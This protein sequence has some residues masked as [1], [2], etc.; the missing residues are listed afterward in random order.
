MV[1][2]PQHLAFINRFF[3][4]IDTAQARNLSLATFNYLAV[5]EEE[6][7]CIWKANLFLNSAPSK[8]PFNHFQSANI[9]AGNYR[10]DEI[11][12]RP[13]AIVDALLAGRIQTPHG[14]LCF[15]S[16][17]IGNYGVTYEPFHAAGIKEQ[18]RL[19][20]LRLLGGQNDFTSHPKLDWELR[21][22]A[23]PYEGISDLLN[24]YNIGR[25]QNTATFEVIAFNAAAVDFRSSVSGN[26]AKVGIFLSH[27]LQPSEVTLGYRELAQ[28]RVVRRDRISG[29]AIAWEQ[30]TETQYGTVEIKVSSAAVLQCFVNYSGVAQQFAWVVDPAVGQNPRRAIYTV[31]DDRMIILQDLI[32]KSGEKKRDARD[33]ESAVAWLL[34]MLGFAVAH[35]GATERTKDAPDLIANT[36]AG[37]FAVVECTTG[38]LKAEHKLANLIDRTQKVRQGLSASNNRHLNILPVIVTSRTRAEVEA[39]LD[40]A[41]RLGIYVITAE[42]LAQLLN[43]LLHSPLP[44]PSAEQ[45]FEQAFAATESAKATQTAAPAI[46]SSPT[47]D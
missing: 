44:Q 47:I 8:T 43:S 19:D 1:I 25:L 31:F 42:G 23:A 32:S 11:E 20:I 46:E 9:R 10:L 45:L 41:S 29:S 22:E 15:K 12:M 3:T 13:R 36:P 37:H 27:G 21:A 17:E 7:F 5:R 26:I 4:T 16:S 30:R 28:G 6:E 40:Q 24:E 38:L 35:L 34:W 33:L 18:S 14:D 2:L 39:D